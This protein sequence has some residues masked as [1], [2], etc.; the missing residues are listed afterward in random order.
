DELNLLR[1]K[2]LDKILDHILLPL[3]LAWFNIDGKNYAIY[4]IGKARER[5]PVALSDTIKQADITGVIKDEKQRPVQF[6][7]VTLLKAADSVMV[8]N[9]LSDTAGRFHF[10]MIKPGDYFVKITAM[11]YQRTYSSLT[12]T[13]GPALTIL[14]RSM[15]IN[16]K[17]VNVTVSHPLVERKEDRFIVNVAGSPMATGNSLQVLRSVPFVEV[18]PDNDIKLQGKT[19]LILINGRPVPDAALLDILQNLPADDI[20]SI[21]LITDPSARYDAS[22]GSVINIRTKKDQSQGLT[23]MVH[24]DL[25]QGDLTRGNLNTRLTYKQGKIT[26]FG[27][28]GA[29]LFNYQTHDDTYR[30]LTLP[31]IADQIHEQIVRTFHG[32]S[33]NF[34]AG[35][36]ID[37]NLNESIGAL[38]DGRS[39]FGPVSFNSTDGFNKIGKPL[40]SV[41]TTMSNLRNTSSGFDY[42]I[43]YHLLADRG[44]SE[45]TVFS[46]LSPLRRILSQDFTSYLTDGSG[47]LLDV[48]APY[49]QVN[50]YQFL[51]F[52]T[53]SDY[54]RVLPRNWKL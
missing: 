23:G 16:L 42:N 9:V 12:H 31:G 37:L 48:P 5:M 15:P 54:S 26:L 35:G 32:G 28:A 27:S 51:I 41:L 43:N 3:G 1:E 47:N 13:A 45:L 11:G 6:A 53:Q 8:S 7:T 10:S 17:Q 18:S 38:I 30:N 21:E 46:T 50:T 14:I 33:V 34:Q 22:Y 36:N 52:I 19:T 24:S 44:K 25:T 4:P 39:S 2:Q 49:Q 40:D 29:G 20:A